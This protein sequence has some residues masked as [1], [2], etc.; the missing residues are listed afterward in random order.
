MIPRLGL[1][2]GLSKR[3]LRFP[4]VL[5]TMFRIANRVRYENQQRKSP[6]QF[7]HVF[8]AIPCLSLSLRSGK[9]KLIGSCCLRLVSKLYYSL[10]SRA[11]L[12]VGTS[13]LLERKFVVWPSTARCRSCCVISNK[14]FFFNSLLIVFAFGASSGRRVLRLNVRI[15]LAPKLSGSP[16]LL[17]WS[18]QPSRRKKTLCLEGFIFL[19]N[20]VEDFAREPVWPQHCV[21][22]ISRWSCANFCH[23][24]VQRM[25]HSG[26]TC[27]AMRPRRSHSYVWRISCMWIS[28]FPWK[29][30]MIWSSFWWQKRCFAPQRGKYARALV[31]SGPGNAI[32]SGVGLVA[33]RYLQF[34]GYMVTGTL[35]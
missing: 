35:L 21:A 6:C 25:F 16:A 8:Q 4:P 18:L 23:A 30:P 12:W 24:R 34:F 22:C 1:L 19:F 11:C 31:V 3:I 5:V 33:A 14:Q 28:N 9:K 26:T 13:R 7:G 32:N 2:L 15:N 17:D 27:R 29:V 20:G 10:L